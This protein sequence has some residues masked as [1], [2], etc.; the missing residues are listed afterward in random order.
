MHDKAYFTNVYL[1]VYYII[2]NVPLMHVHGTYSDHGVF[3]VPFRS[4]NKK[5]VTGPE[6]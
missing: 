3:E 6:G 5:N 4:E 1:L 2:L